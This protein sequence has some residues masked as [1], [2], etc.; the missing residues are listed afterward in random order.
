MKAAAV[1]LLIVVLFLYIAS[2]VDAMRPLY[3]GVPACF[4]VAVTAKRII[5]E[6]YWP[7]EPDLPAASDEPRGVLTQAEARERLEEFLYHEW[8]REQCES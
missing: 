1:S 7:T 5:Q 2:E 8:E 4:V 6:I 3:L